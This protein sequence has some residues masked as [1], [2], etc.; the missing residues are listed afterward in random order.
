M[1]E[2]YLVTGVQLAMLTSSS[3][4]LRE[5]IVEEIMKEQFVGRSIYYIEKDAKFLCE[6]DVLKRKNL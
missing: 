2:R 1:A 3:R 5:K 4:E 6:N